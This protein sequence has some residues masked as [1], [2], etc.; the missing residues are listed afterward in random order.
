VRGEEDK[1]ATAIGSHMVDPD[2]IYVFKHKN[3][4]NI[5]KTIVRKTWKTS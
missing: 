5:A 2:F 1:K 4:L 3:D